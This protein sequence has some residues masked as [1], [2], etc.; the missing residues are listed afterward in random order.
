MQAKMSINET[1]L[2]SAARV[3]LASAAR[4]VRILPVV[5][6]GLSA[7]GSNTTDPEPDVLRVSGTYATAVSLTENSCGSGIT[8]LPNPTVVTH[9]AGASTLGLQHGP[10]S[11]T[12]TITTSAAFT[13]QPNVVQNGGVQSTLNIVGQFTL[14]GFTATVT[15]DVVQAQAPTTCRYKVGWVGTKQGAANTIP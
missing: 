3:R 6:V 14:T 5:I 1:R 8:V 11:Y 13:T 15:V 4:L 9:T 12:G 2:R 7:C 10:L